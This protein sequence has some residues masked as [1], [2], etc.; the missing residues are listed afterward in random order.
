MQ[1]GRRHDSGGTNE[2]RVARALSQ[3]LI[4]SNENGGW[5]SE[6]RD[7]P[8]CARRYCWIVIIIIADDCSN[9][10]VDSSGNDDDDDDDND[11]DIHDGKDKND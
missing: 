1:I 9:A 11:V 6:F 5:Y 10:K 3:S 8:F 4:F 7:R 2:A